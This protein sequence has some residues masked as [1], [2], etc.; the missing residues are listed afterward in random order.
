VFEFGVSGEVTAVHAS[1]VHL[2][3]AIGPEMSGPAADEQLT[4]L[5]AVGRQVDL[6]M[7]R[8][9][10]RV[11]R[12]GQSS[13]DGV[14]STAAFVRRKVNERGEWVSKRVAVGRALADRLPSKANADPSSHADTARRPMAIGIAAPAV[15]AT[16]VGAG[17]FAG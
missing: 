11:D 8:V 3:A 4:E 5:L 15:P 16:A 17:G 14:A 9:V 10:E 2:A 13:A 12:T 6:A 7:C 1:V